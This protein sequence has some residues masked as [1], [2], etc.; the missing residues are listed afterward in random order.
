MRQLFFLTLGAI[1]MWSSSL[2][3]AYVASPWSLK[4]EGYVFVLSA[5]DEQNE[6]DANI[7]KELKDKDPKGLNLLMFVRYSESPV[8][9]YN[10]LLY[11]PGKLS[12]PNGNTDLSITRIYVDSEESLIG[13]QNNWGIPKE[14]ADFAIKGSKVAVSVLGEEAASFE[15]KAFGPSFPLSTGLIPEN[16]RTL[17]QLR[18]NKLF[19]FALSGKG[20][21]NFASLKPISGNGTLFPDLSKRRVI[22]G[23]HIEDFSLTFPVADIQDYLDMATIGHNPLIGPG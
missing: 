13:G 2:A 16:F 17:T 3:H 10:E 9:P 23:F 6:I 1:A 15:V 12:F 5:S 18:E 22:A 21:A 7:P 20:K 14:M 19:T 4:G 11:I 8:G